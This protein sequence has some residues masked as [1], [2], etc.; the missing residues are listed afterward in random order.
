MYLDGVL[1]IKASEH[2][3][4]LLKLYELRQLRSTRGLYNIE[5]PF[6][7]L[8]VFFSCKVR[9]IRYQVRVLNE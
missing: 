4:K 3:R 9:F 8:S 2:A 6:F 5:L 7:H 1:T